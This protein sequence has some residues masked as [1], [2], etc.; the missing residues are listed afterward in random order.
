MARASGKARPPAAAVVADRIHSAAI[1]LL[2]AARRQDPSTGLSPARLSALSVLVFGG[3]STLKA[4]SE[5]EQV[6]PPTMSRIVDALVTAG[7]AR[8]TESP[9][10]G[11]AWRIRAT[12]RGRAV[13]KRGRENRVAYLAERLAGLRPPELAALLLAAD[14]IERTMKAAGGA[15]ASSQRPPVKPP[16]SSGSAAAAARPASDRAGPSSPR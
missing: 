2:R 12:A 16:C 5:A 4:L 6:R 15:G 3:P 8:R 10:D 7:L 1:R 11:R 14:L 9:E 13:L